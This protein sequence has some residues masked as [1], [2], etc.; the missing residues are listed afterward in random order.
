MAKTMDKTTFSLI[1][2]IGLKSAICI[3]KNCENVP[4]CKTLKNFHTKSSGF[5]ITLFPQFDLTVETSR[6][7]GI[8]FTPSSTKRILKLVK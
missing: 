1:C 6:G 3:K 2:Y 7:L 8:E 4:K 5:K